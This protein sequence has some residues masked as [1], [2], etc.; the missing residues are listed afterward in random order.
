MVG[1]LY[2]AVT[3]VRS[4]AGIFVEEMRRDLHPAH[5]HAD[6]HITILPP[7]ALSGTEEQA[8]HQLKSLC[9]TVVP[10]EVTMGDVESF[11]PATPTVFIRVAHGA[12][13]FRELHDRLNGGALQ[14]NEPWPYMPHLTI[15][16]MDTIDEARKVVSLTRPRWDQCDNNRKIR[17]DKLT[18]VKG[19]GE[20][21]ID[22]ASIPLGG[23]PPHKPNS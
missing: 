22:L 10:F 21:W 15:V 20:R 6:A 16:K 9:R 11:I 2:A 1:L 13:R 3:Y 4:P 8:I 18:F 23:A 14:C 7:R 12:Y 19:V 17:I 5:T